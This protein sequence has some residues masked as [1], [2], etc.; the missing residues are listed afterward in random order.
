[1]V[2]IIVPSSRLAI[3]HVQF[4]A[5]STSWLISAYFEDVFSIYRPSIILYAKT[6]SARI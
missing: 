6:K 5:V 3:W 2:K 1:M 4:V